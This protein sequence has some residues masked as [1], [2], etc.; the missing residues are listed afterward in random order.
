MIYPQRHLQGTLRNSY[1]AIPQSP[2]VSDA[3]GK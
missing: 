1:S 2:L 3:E